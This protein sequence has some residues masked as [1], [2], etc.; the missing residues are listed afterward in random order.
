MLDATLLTTGTVATV[1][2]MRPYPYLQRLDPYLQ[3]LGYDFSEE[4]HWPRNVSLWV[5]DGVY[6]RT[7]IDVE[8]DNYGQSWDFTYIP[9]NEG[10]LD[11][12]TEP[13][14]WPFFLTRMEVERRMMGRHV[15]QRLVWPKARQAEKALRLRTDD[16]QLLTN[17]GRLDPAKAHRQLWKRLRSGI[18]VWIVNGRLVRS[19]FDL[20]FTAGG[21]DLVYPR[22]VPRGEVWIDDDV[23]EGE[24][25]FVLIHELRERSLM[26]K[27]RSYNTAHDSANRFESACRRELVDLDEALESVGWY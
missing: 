9:A 7:N 6:I 20:D 14:E 21:H 13:D 5:V 24:R 23:A 16:L 26:A 4:I 3:R 22:Y 19:G 18:R 11:R 1:R 15:A 12:E 2:G 25:P 8:F 27:G 17:R 10:W